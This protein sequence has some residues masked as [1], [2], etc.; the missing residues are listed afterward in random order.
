MDY[1]VMENFLLD[2]KGQKPSVEDQSWKE[3]FELD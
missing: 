3:E 1:L 2:K